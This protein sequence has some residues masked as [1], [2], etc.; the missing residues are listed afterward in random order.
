MAKLRVLA[1]EDQ[2]AM[3]GEFGGAGQAEA[4][5]LRDVGLPIDPAAAS[6]R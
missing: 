4:V 2:I 6:D 1:G 5:Y 3:T